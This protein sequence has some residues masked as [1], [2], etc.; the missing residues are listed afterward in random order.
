MAQAS[1]SH[2]SVEYNVLLC[3]PALSEHWDT[4]PEN[5]EQITTVKTYQ[6][7]HKSKA[8][9]NSNVLPCIFSWVKSQLLIRTLL[10]PTCWK[11]SWIILK[12][13]WESIKMVP[14]TRR[15]VYLLVVSPIRGRC[16]T[17]GSLPQ[18]LP[19]MVILRITVG[20]FYF[21]GKKHRPFDFIYTTL[22]SWDILQWREDDSATFRSDRLKFWI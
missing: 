18:T 5:A 14:W 17:K 12:R 22:F 19:F 9:V 10:T 2:I 16:K 11:W 8:I 21:D 13:F 3:S 4:I 15:K 6:N 1:S 20:F 7:Y